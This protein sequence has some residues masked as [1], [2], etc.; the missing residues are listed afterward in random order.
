MSDEFKQDFSERGETLADTVLK[1][2]AY[3]DHF[4]V[5]TVKMLTN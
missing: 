2:Y 1:Q 5:V 4:T 3:R